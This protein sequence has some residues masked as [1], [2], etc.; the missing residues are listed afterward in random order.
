MIDCPP[1]DS[2]VSSCL[3]HAI[4]IESDE[5]SVSPSHKKIVI[6]VG[7]LLPFKESWRSSS[8]HLR[9]SQITPVDTE[10][11]SSSEQYSTTLLGELIVKESAFGDSN[12]ST[13]VAYDVSIDEEGHLTLKASRMAIGDESGKSCVELGALEIKH[14]ND[15]PDTAE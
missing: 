1:C 6:S 7:T 3:E 10:D 5:S 15:S 12:D 9:V 11:V 4:W 8:H 14:C 13:L 2:L